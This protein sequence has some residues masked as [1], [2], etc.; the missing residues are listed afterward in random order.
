M[1]FVHVAVV[2]LLCLA[3]FLAFAGQ[4]KVAGGLFVLSTFLEIIGA[5]IFGKQRNT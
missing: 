3:A 1:K 5:M 4:S 2:L